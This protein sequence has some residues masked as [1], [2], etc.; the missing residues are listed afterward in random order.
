VLHRLSII[1][2][3]AVVASSGAARRPVSASDTTSLGHTASHCDTT[4]GRGTSLRDYIAPIVAAVGPAADSARAAF[5]LP[6]GPASIVTVV[7]D[8]SVCTAVYNAQVRLKHGGDSTVVG[9]IGLV[10]VGSTRYL[11]EDIGRTAGEWELL[12]IYDSNLKY[13]GSITR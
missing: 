8:D 4:R 3:A 2:I 12:D 9:P 11:L 13:L 7:T 6:S 5:D 10:Q 1:G